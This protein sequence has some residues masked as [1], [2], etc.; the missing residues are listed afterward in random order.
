[1]VGRYVPT[2]IICVR[3]K[4]KPWFDNLCRRVS[5]SIRRLIFGGPVIA[6]GLIEKSL[7]AVKSDLMKYTRRPSI[8]LV[9]ETLMFS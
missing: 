3:N 4:G 6:L 2:K 9:S 1:M 8:S 7:F 5:T